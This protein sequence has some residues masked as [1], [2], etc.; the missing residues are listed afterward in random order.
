MTHRHTP[1]LIVLG[2]TIL[3]SIIVGYSLYTSDVF[4]EEIQPNNYIV[5]LQDG[6]SMKSGIGLGTHIVLEDVLK[7]EDNING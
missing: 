4:E 6:L 3:T 1:K 5:D 2:F 7:M